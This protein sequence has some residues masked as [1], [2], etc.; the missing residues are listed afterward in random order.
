MELITNLLDKTVLVKSRPPDKNMGTI[1]AVWIDRNMLMAVVVMEDGAFVTAEVNNLEMPMAM[2]LFSVWV[3]WGPNEKIKAIKAVR[4]VT[5]MSLKDAKDHVENHP[6][7]VLVKD[8][9]TL[10]DAEE[11]KRQLIMDNNMEVDI[12]RSV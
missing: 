2:R 6:G 10:T 7:L 3:F 11:L 8:K 5:G 4:G 1:S 9:L 12:R